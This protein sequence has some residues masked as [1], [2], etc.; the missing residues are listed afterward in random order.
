MDNLLI[1]K[2]IDSLFHGVLDVIES[3]CILK[4][5]SEMIKIERVTGCG[6]ICVEICTFKEFIEAVSTKKDSTSYTL[7]DNFV[8]TKVSSAYYCFASYFPKDQN[9][10][11]ANSIS[12][13]TRI[14]E[15]YQFIDTFV[16]ALPYKWS[17]DKSRTAFCEHVRS[18][19]IR[20]FI[21][22]YQARILT[23]SM[24]I[25]QTELLLDAY[26]LGYY[27]FGWSLGENGKPQ[28]LLCYNVL[29][30]YPMSLPDADL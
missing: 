5:Q 23:L 12:Y 2:L 22:I 20:H 29:C 21:T 17:S 30:P 25:P 15:N 16:D 28:S 19:I 13:I 18:T 3:P 27:P 9:K 4:G 24:R 11:V 14:I 8:I 26:S 10:F 6:V 1:V 7:L